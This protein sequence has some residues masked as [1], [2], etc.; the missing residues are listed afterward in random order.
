VP[1]FLIMFIFSMWKYHLKSFEVILSSLLNILHVI[2]FIWCVIVFILHIIIIMGSL[3]N[4]CW[5]DVL[6]YMCF[7]SL[8]WTSWKKYCSSSAMVII[9]YLISWLCLSFPCGNTIWNLLKWSLAPYS[10]YCM[11]SGL[12]GVMWL[13]SFC[14]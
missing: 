1:Y 2:R 5:D 4:I 11:W 14:I 12:F 7:F 3:L 13:C 10:T 8:N 6:F 9:W